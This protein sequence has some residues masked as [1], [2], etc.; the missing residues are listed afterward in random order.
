MSFRRRTMD[1][2]FPFLFGPSALHRRSR[3]QCLLESLLESSLV[4][5]NS[6]QCSQIVSKL[7][8]TNCRS[9]GQLYRRCSVRRDPIA[10]FVADC[11][12]LAN[13]LASFCAWGARSAHRF[14]T[15]SLGAGGKH[16]FCCDLTTPPAPAPG[17]TTQSRLSEFL[18]TLS[19]LAE[20]RQRQAVT[21]PFHDPF[22]STYSFNRP[23][24]S[25]GRE[26][27]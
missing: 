1:G 12:L 3:R 9:F 17:L 10:F 4:P 24:L 13:F 16:G 8:R 25:F 21:L 11:V 5:G 26:G 2:V 14:S 7:A 15:S 20:P 27:L 23:R 19:F 18:S 22:L 6:S